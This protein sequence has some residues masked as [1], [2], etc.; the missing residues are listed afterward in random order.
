ML[1]SYPQKWQQRKWLPDLL[2]KLINQFFCERR[3]WKQCRSIKPDCNFFPNCH[4]CT[5]TGSKYFLSGNDF[6]YIWKIPFSINFTLLRNRGDILDI[7]IWQHFF[8]LTKIIWLYD[9][10]CSKE[11]KT[12][13]WFHRIVLQKL[14]TVSRAYF[15][16]L[17]EGLAQRFQ[18][19]QLEVVQTWKFDREGENQNWDKSTRM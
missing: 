2:S 12:K 3:N 9:H 7:V 6:R 13:F 8:R 16:Y 19:L 14:K 11:N 17:N 15:K 18:D 4:Y 5:N 10:I 1:A